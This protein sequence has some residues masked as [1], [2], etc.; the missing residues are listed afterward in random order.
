MLTYLIGSNHLPPI[1]A[2]IKRIKTIKEVLSTVVDENRVETKI[3][4]QQVPIL[5]LR[6]KKKIFPLLNAFFAER[7]TIIL[8]DISR[9]KSQK[10][11]IDPSKLH[12]N[13]YS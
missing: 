7:K 1:K 2:R 4:P 6:K 8:V 12:A 11:S 13:D 3:S 9:K 10:T 5:L